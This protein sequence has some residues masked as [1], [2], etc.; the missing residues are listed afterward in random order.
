MVYSKEFNDKLHL[1]DFHL[2]LKDAS[3]TDHK[4]LQG[5]VML[6]TLP[7]DEATGHLA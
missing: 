6:P 7:R 1:S 5:K 3:C 2:S 4:P